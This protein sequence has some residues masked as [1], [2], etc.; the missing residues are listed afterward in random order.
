MRK[1]V[2]ANLWMFV[3]ATTL[4]YHGGSSVT[5]STAL[6]MELGAHLGIPRLVLGQ[7]FDWQSYPG[8]PDA[9]FWIIS[10]SDT[11]TFAFRV[12]PSLPGCSSDCGTAVPR[13]WCLCHIMMQGAHHGD[14]PG[15]H[16][17]NSCISHNLMHLR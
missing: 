4:R 13:T 8:S 10:L 7:H 6:E 3:R 2:Q 15:D 1:K 11:V 17:H 12:W 9:F 5:P 16:S 14:L